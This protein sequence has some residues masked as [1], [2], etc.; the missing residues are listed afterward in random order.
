MRF[1]HTE[2]QCE[3][4]YEPEVE[5]GYH[6]QYQYLYYSITISITNR[7][8]LNPTSLLTLNPR[9]SSTKVSMISL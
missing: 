3:N 2:Y 5:D 8:H 6:Y 4:E 1:T 9:I 7:I